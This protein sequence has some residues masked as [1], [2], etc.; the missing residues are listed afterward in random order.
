MISIKLTLG[1]DKVK[2]FSAMG[3]EM[4]HALDLSNPGKNTHADN[5]GT[6]DSDAPDA[7]E[8]QSRLRN[9]FY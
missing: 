3:G 5:M 1:N 7:D 9:V 2:P 6:A 4:R 8:R